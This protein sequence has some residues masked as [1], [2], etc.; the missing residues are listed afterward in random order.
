MTD[1]T[2]IYSNNLEQFT[3]I[4]GDRQT[5]IYDIFNSK[6]IPL[7]LV[8][9]SCSVCI[10]KYGDPANVLDVCAGSPVISGSNDN[11]FIAYFSASNISHASGVYQQQV[12]IQDYL[13]NIHIPAQ[14]KIIIFPGVGDELMMSESEGGG[15]V[16][17]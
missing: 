17:G 6:G 14:G 16:G 15:E 8:D 1:F 4:A 7:S 2:T 12:R 9:T 5:L 3:M 10:F 13:G 11:R